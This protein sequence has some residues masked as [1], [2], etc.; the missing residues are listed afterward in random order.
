MFASWR[1]ISNPARSTLFLRHVTDVNLA[2]IGNSY[3][4]SDWVNAS[5]HFHSDILLN[6]FIID[7]ACNLDASQR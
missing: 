4:R 1:Y 6:F 3:L 5:L 7:L 2:F